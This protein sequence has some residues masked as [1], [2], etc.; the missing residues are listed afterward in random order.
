[1][2]GLGVRVLV[3][4]HDGYIGSVVAPTLRDAG[5]DVV[6]VDTYFYEDCSFGERLDEIPSLRRDVRDV[7]ELDL[8]GFDAVVHLAALSND[9]LGDL[10]PALTEA[11]NFR[12]TVR[13]AAAA[14][15]TGVERFVFASSCSMYGV[16]AGNAPVDET[17][18]LRPLTPYAVSKVKAE[19]ALAEL[20]GPGFSPVFM[21]NATAYGVSPRLRADLVV[22]NLAGWAHTTGAIRLLSDGTAWRPLVH[23]ED[24]AR[25]TA[26]LLDAPTELVHC[27]AFNVGAPGEN[28]RVRELAELVGEAAPGCAVEYAPG[29]GADKRSYRVSFEK[30]RRT[31]PEFDFRWTAAAGAAEL[32][33]AYRRRGLTVDD[34]KGPRF[35]RLATLRRLLSDA[36]IDADL[37]WSSPVPVLR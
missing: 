18:P 25:V 24:I 37:R 26:L 17:A 27:T 10:D 29:G 5:H 6:G 35:T 8:E 4:G 3:T 13:L 19:S 21:R 33:D 1:M 12:A 31:F 34:F 32:L 22:N 14:K 28:Y 30:L 23:V 16:V 2:E 15:R 9:P 11:I 36:S 7:D 20:A